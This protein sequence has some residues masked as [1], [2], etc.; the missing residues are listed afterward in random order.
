MVS[1]YMLI[2]FS[3][4]AMWQQLPKFKMHITWHLSMT[5]IGD[6]AIDKLAHMC[7]KKKG[8]WYLL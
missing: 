5:L 7:K 8:R 4:K 1:K 6:Y 2:C 3:W